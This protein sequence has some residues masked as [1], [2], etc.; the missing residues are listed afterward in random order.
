M[1]F[2]FR[3]LSHRAG[4]DPL[5]ECRWSKRYVVVARLPSLMCV[6]TYTVV[7]ISAC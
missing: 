6:M 1:F 5:F 4:A 3:V 7:A 2:F